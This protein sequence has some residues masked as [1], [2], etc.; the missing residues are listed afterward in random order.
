MSIAQ[1]CVQGLRHCWGAPPRT[2]PKKSGE[3]FSILTLHLGC[4][5]PCGTALVFRGRDWKVGGHR[6]LCGLLPRPYILHWLRTTSSKLLPWGASTSWPFWAKPGGISED[7]G[8]FASYCSRLLLQALS[9][10]LAVALQMGETLPP[11]P[12]STR[13]NPSPESP[14]KMSVTR[15][16]QPGPGPGGSA[17]VEDLSSDR[18]N[19]GE[20]LRGEGQGMGT[21][22]GA[23]ARKVCPRAS[24]APPLSRRV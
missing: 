19:Q 24:G 4:K 2:L 5:A 22:H 8:A 18:L 7:T 6:L 12:P 9:V 14:A 17:R 21:G 3:P 10:L 23:E 20:V 13:S 11:S 1:L 16:K 15:G